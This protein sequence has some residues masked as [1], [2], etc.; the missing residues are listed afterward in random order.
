[1]AQ[2]KSKTSQLGGGCLILFALPFAA[3]GVFMGGWSAM[4]LLDYTRMRGWQEVPC[5][6]VKAEL[7]EHSDSDGTTYEVMAEYRYTFNGQEHT[8]TRVSLDS[9][10]DNI[11]SFQQDAHKELSRHRQQRRPFR[12]F[13]DP[14]EPS[15]SVLYR[16]LR[17]GLLAMKI[18]FALVFGGVGFGLIIGSVFA[19]RK[20]TAEKQ[21]TVAHPD[22]PWL[23]KE[24]WATGQIRSS[25]KTTMWVALGFAAFWNLVS[26][27][28]LFFVPEEVIE[29]ENYL[30]LL[31][32][33]FPLV[34]LG[35]IVWAARAVLRWRKYGESVFEMAA[36][37]GLLGGSLAGVIRA[38]KP[39]APPD[40]FRQVLSCIEKTTSGSGKNRSTTETTRWQDERVIDR[41]LSGPGEPTAV[42]VAFAVPYD[43][44]AS[45]IESERREI[46]WRLEVSAAVPGI[47]Y[48][49]AFDV[50]VFKT[51]Q[52][53]PDFKLDDDLIANYAA[54]RD[55]EQELRRTGILCMPAPAGQGDRYV[56]P[57]FR[58]AGAIVGLG[59]FTAIWTGV[60][61]G[62]WYSDAPLLFPIVFSGFGLLLVL[63][64]LDVAFYRSVVDVARDGINVSGGL[65]GMG[66]LRRIDAGQLAELRAV[67]GMQSGKRLYYGVAAITHD[68]KKITLGKRLPNKQLAELVIEQMRRSMES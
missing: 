11:G 59:L 18:V 37:P 46:T 65:F 66:R 16:E 39:L 47:D 2:K 51:E 9:G 32:L 40:G 48:H 60:C 13:V 50:P 12:C 34:G 68:A 64:L 15:E 35:L 4:T 56:F 67:R 7:E 3:V 27:P 42:P 1:M 30:A 26:S 63:G 43:M 19:R 41:P 24:E 57:M 14:D 17:F 5:T 29:K 54:R 28:V 44:P 45:T 58:N 31:G 49:A 20:T 36:T 10:A 53:R 61:V 23:W 33:L 25:S 52:S 21:L 55:P 6:I 8:G 22:R 62:L 38:S